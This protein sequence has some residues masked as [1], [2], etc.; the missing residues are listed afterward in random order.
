MLR[1]FQ[2]SEFADDAVRPERCQQIELAAARRL[3]AAVGEVDDLALLRPVDR[4]M[5]LVDE[6]FQPF[7]QPVVA[8]R[9]PAVAV[10]ALLDDDP[11]GVVGDDEAVQIEVEAVL[12]GGRVDLGDEPADLG[13]RVAVE[14][15]A[16][17]DGD[18][19]LRRLARMRAAPAADMQ[20]EFA[21]QRLQARASARR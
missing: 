18:K 11:A 7:G 8:A 5:R 21:R 14:A 12:D 13:Q 10:H 17:A 20:A 2:R 16:L 1:R 9:L 6:A 15:D 3:G 19:L 4:G